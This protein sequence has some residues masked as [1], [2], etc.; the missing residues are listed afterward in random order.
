MHSRQGRQNVSKDGQRKCKIRRPWSG[1][2][3]AVKKQLKE[4][5]YVAKEP[6]R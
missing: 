2:I 4:E 1:P 5:T 6:W 3:A